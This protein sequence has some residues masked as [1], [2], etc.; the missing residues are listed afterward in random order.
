[1]PRCPDSSSAWRRALQRA[2]PAALGLI[3]LAEPAT[4]TAR[5]PSVLLNEVLYDPPGAD[6]GHEFVELVSRRDRA[7][8]LAGLRL[9]F[10]NGARPG[11]WLLLWEGGAVDSLPAGGLYLIGEDAVVGADAQVALGLQNGPDALRLRQGDEVLDL[12]GYGEGLDSTLCEAWPAD[13]AAGRSL[14]RRPDGVDTDQNALDWFVSRPTPG[15]WN[16]PDFRAKL[17]GA[18][19]G[20]PP[21]V[22]HAP[23]VLEAE[24]ENRGAAPWP[25]SLRLDVDGELSVP[26]PSTPPG[27]RCRLSLTLPGRAPG[28]FTLVLKLALPGEPLADSL[29]VAGRVGVG[30]LLL[31]E[32]LFA[33]RGGE[34]E[35]IEC[36]VREALLPGARFRIAD[37]SGTEAQFS[38]P[39][40]PVGECFLLCGDAAALLGH[41]PGLAAPRIVELSPW[42]SLANSGDSEAAPGWTEGL[43]LDDEA[44]R[45]VDG[46]LYRGDWIPERGVSLERVQLHP[47]T[48]V[49]PWSAC[50]TG[51]SPLVATLPASGAAGLPSTL[52]LEPNPFDPEREW[53]RIRVAEPNR[54]LSLEIFDASGNSVQRLETAG[55]SGLA[56][57]VW[58]GRDDAGR[59]LPDG[60]YPLI[61]DLEDAGGRRRRLRGVCALLR[62]G[63]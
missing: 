28:A 51:S 53:L 34:P 40:L 13:D 24:A 21:L 62:R 10:C 39:A 4:G 17:L 59:A 27:S 36:V 15:D 41:R 38:P 48:A 58:D 52:E 43:R 35:W 25:E 63:G 31:S 44:G 54:R 49:A 18:D 1:M 11:E 32:V 9:E 46:L 42:P 2:V 7:Q 33:P 37:L 20:F 45:R 47:G 60:A 55:G 5:A 3:L 14:A 8:G 56:R 12:L 29:A 26:L 22:P 50:P 6:G 19:T 57:L 30:P 16:L 23:I 61:L